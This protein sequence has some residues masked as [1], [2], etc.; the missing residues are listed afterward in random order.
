VDARDCNSTHEVG[1]DFVVV[2]TSSKDS[3][4]LDAY[5]KKK[6]KCGTYVQRFVIQE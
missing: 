3:K 2:G 5:S 1:I 4:F 6:R